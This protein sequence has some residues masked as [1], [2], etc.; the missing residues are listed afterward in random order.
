MTSGPFIQ[1]EGGTVSALEHKLDDLKDD[2]NGINTRLDDMKTID[3]PMSEATMDF[4]KSLLDA[5]SIR[6]NVYKVNTGVVDGPMQTYQWGEKEHEQDG[7]AGCQKIL[8]KDL[9][10][11]YGIYDIRSRKLPE[12]QVGK[13]KSNGFSDMAL[14]PKESMD[15]ATSFAKDLVLSYSVA[16]VELKTGRADLKQGQLLLQ[17][18]AL[19][20]ISEKRQ[21]AVVLGTDCA[22]KWRLLY[23]I[24]YNNIVVQPYSNGKKCLADFKKLIATGA[25]RMEQ[26]TAPKK[27]TSIAEGSDENDS[28]LEG[29]DLPENRRDEAIAREHKLIRLAGALGSLYG[30]NLE[31]PYWAK[32]SETC[33]SYYM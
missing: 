3:V 32:A 19:S 5:L 20:E 29:F 25:A 13:R 17:L 6:F 26:N 24:S 22:T 9:P 15:Y 23:F 18:L 10:L 33:L 31:V 1:Q 16:L 21:G 27:L 4:T 30:E 14:G 11:G 28:M 2:L 8:G 12:L 7:Q